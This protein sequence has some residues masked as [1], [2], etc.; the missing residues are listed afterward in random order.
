MSAANPPIRTGLRLLGV[1]T[2]FAGA[3][4]LSARR[5][6]PIDPQQISSELRHAFLANAI[7]L[8]V[9]TTSD[10]DGGSSIRLLE[11]GRELTGGQ[12]HADIRKDG[13][14]RFSHW[15][16][17]IYFSSSDD[18]NPRTNGRSHIE[19]ASQPS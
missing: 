6:G 12:Q 4:P 5:L 3:L 15:G 2:V 13:A 8:G 11:D 9:T 16:S 18:S 19:C 17:H 1:L 7:A 14:G 10:A